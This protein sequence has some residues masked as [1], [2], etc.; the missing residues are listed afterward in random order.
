M[1]RITFSPLIVEASGKV[2]DTV[3]SKWKGRN[4]IRSRVTPANPNTAAQQAVRTSLARCVEMWQSLSPG[5]QGW[6]DTYASPYSLSGYNSFMS[7]NRALEQAGSE[8]KC[9]PH[10][11]NVTKQ[12]TMT[13]V[14]GV[15]SGEI[16]LTWT[17]GDVGADIYCA[18]TTR[19]SGTNVLATFS[20][21]TTLNSV[22]SV[23]VTGLTP[24]TSYQI[25][26]NVN[27]DNISE[28]SES[29]ADTATSQ[30]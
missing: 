27:N 19:E 14:T 28:A 7:A 4:Y 22:G 11:A 16:D 15:A 20:T 23:T 29:L 12:S 26:T 13:A 8:L 21:V 17:G 18:I 10:N 30:T 24:T 6:W 9:F 25:Y 5:R 3:F 1:A 2:K